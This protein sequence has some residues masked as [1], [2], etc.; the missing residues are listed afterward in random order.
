MIVVGADTVVGR[1]I[2]EGFL[3]PQREI[4]AFVTDPVCAEELK[5]LGVKTALGDVSD[6]THVGAACTNVH[7]AVLI[8]EAAIDDRE[9]AFAISYDQVFDGW[10]RAISEASV[11]R[12]I[13]VSTESHPT[14]LAPE[15]VDVSPVASTDEIVR[16][17]VSLDS[18]ASIRAQ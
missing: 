16:S 15:E 12:V 10:A 7:T 17:V 18:S 2:I 6:D 14:D 9:R 4:R 11:K 5:R 8:G 1:A 3:D 13:W